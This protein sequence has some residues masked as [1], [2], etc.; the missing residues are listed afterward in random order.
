MNRKFGSMFIIVMVIALLVNNNLVI[1]FAQENGLEIIERSEYMEDGI[2]YKTTIEEL[3]P[4][5]E[6]VLGRAAMKSRTLSKT[7]GAYNSAGKELWTVTLKATFN[8]NGSTSYASASSVSTSV[9]SS[10]L[11]L[12]KH[13]KRALNTATGQATA[14]LSI[15]GMPVQQVTKTVTLTCNKNGGIT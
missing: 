15:A 13:T 5:N 14:R 9:N 11:I 1:V 2:V 4:E 6:I 12:S 3:T 7:L 8:Y 10:W